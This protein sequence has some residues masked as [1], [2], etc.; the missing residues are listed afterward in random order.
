MGS[1]RPSDIGSTGLRVDRGVG[2][3]YELPGH[4]MVR[5]RYWSKSGTVNAVSP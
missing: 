3:F 1:K 4:G 2:A 5:R